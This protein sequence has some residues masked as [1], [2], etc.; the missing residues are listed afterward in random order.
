[1]DGFFFEERFFRI[2]AS[3][4]LYRAIISCMRMSFVLFFILS[5]FLIPVG[6]VAEELPI[7]A[8]GWQPKARVYLFNVPFYRQQS[9][10][11]CE[12]A[13]LRSALKA[14]GVTVSEWDLWARLRKDFTKR[15]VQADGSLVWGDPNKGFVGNKDGSMP[16]TGYGVFSPPIAELANWYATSSIIRV[17]DPYVIDRAL[18]Q[19]HPIIIWSAVGNPTVM[20]WKTLEGRMI[21]APIREHTRVIVGY[22][23]TSEMI[24]GLYIID[25]LTSLQYISWNDFHYHNSFFNHVGLEVM[26]EES[27]AL[28]LQSF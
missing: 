16:K 13:S 12:I 15:S 19:G 20:S 2:F 9:S 22:R 1:M 4:F 21:Q 5:L 23:G 28:D 3:G 17:D 8:Q 18:S 24:E 25:P 10:L 26:P 14:I 27:R 6:A 7:G 11:T